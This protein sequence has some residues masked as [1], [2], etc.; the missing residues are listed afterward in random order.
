MLQYHRRTHFWWGEIRFG[1]VAF[2]PKF[3]LQLSVGQQH[4]GEKD[5]GPNSVAHTHAFPKNVST[6]VTAKT[7]TL[8]QR[9]CPTKIRRERERV[10]NFSKLPARVCVCVCVFLCHSLSAAL[11]TLS[12]DC[13]LSHYVCLTHTSIVV[14][15]IA[16][17]YKKRKGK[18][19]IEMGERKSLTII[20][21]GMCKCVRACALRAR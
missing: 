7:P 3:S 16:R 20:T 6:E 5:D 15:F 4:L 12:L 9:V 17:R 14:I 8:A 19:E 13:C 10:E 1:G 21:H 2:G 11:C 18:R